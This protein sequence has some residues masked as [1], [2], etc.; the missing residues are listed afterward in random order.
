MV[1]FNPSLSS[2]KT[3]KINDDFGE[4]EN[5]S[6]KYYYNHYEDS[7]DYENTKWEY[8]GMVCKETG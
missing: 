5:K 2:L 7:E 3:I 4:Y 8:T 1:S 6:E